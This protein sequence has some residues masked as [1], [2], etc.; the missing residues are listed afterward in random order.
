[1]Q[2]NNGGATHTAIVLILLPLTADCRYI[3]VFMFIDRRMIIDDDTITRLSRSRCSLSLF[4]SL[5]NV[6]FT[7]LRFFFFSC[8]LLNKIRKHA[9]KRNYG[10]IETK[11]VEKR[12]VCACVCVCVCVVYYM[13]RQLW[14]A[15]TGSS[16]VAA[17]RLVGRVA[18]PFLFSGI[19]L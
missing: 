11:Q 17:A 16:A 10:G 6:I 3:S 8:F 14:P 5:C 4:L 18:E 19:F 7:L 9:Q 2:V 13:R 1:M 12:S 15:I